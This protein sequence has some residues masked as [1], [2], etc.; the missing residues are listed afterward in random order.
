M[1]LS[2]HF[3]VQEN[4]SIYNSSL[5]KMPLIPEKTGLVFFFLI[6][7]FTACSLVPETQIMANKLIT[8]LQPP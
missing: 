7:I 2:K 6:L 8:I 5:H 3:L 4:V 1:N